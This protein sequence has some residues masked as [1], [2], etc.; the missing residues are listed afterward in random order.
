M[1]TDLRLIEIFGKMIDSATIYLGRHV[2]LVNNMN[3][4]PVPDGDTGTNMFNTLNGIKDRTMNRSRFTHLSDY[5]NE[6]SQA[7][8]YEGRGNSGIILSQ[9]LQ[10][11]ASEFNTQKHLTTQSFASCLEKARES[12]YESVGKPVEGT[13]LTVLSDLSEVAKNNAKNYDICELFEQITIA[14]GTSV[15]QTTDLSLIHI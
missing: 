11:F 10:G 1:K 12:A 15:H 6:V 2:D 8:L 14:A 13:I 4:F 3:V 9:I 5:L 7:P